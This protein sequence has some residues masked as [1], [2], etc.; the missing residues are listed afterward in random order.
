MIRRPPRS[1]RTDTLCPYTT[2]F[3]SPARRHERKH[4]ARQRRL[5]RAIGSDDPGQRPRAERGADAVHHRAATERDADLV[6][7]D[8]HHN[9]RSRI[10]WR[11]KTGTPRKA[12]TT[13]SFSPFV[14]GLILTP[15][16]ASVGTAAPP[17]AAGSRIPA[18]RG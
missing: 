16:S 1:T 4:R 13:P 3:R 2:L 5:A 15:R 6:Q 8:V 11:R 10:R 12:V 14:A 9:P 18:T 7:R 17:I